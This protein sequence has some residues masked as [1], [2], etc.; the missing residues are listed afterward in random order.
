MQIPESLYL[1]YKQRPR[2]PTKNYSVYVTDP[3]D[4]TYINSLVEGIRNAAQ[5]DGFN[6]SQTVDF[7]VSFVQSLPYTFDNVTTPYDEYPRYPVETLVDN[8]GDCEDT[9]ILMAAVLQ[10]MGYGVV[11]ITPPKHCAVGVLGGEGISGTYWEYK[12]G[13]Y[14]FLETTGE[15]WKIGQL[16]PDYKG[17]QASVYG[18]VPV[19]VLT[20]HWTSVSEGGLVKLTVKVENLGSALADDVHVFAGFDAGATQVWNAERSPLFN[21]GP[22]GGWVTATLYLRPPANQRTRLVVEIVDDGYKVDE[23]RS[24][25]FQT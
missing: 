9:S 10:G 17:A 25:W 8:G 11:L 22:G 19:P 12:G 21:V 7:A 13:K 2:P 15:G 18:M 5:R 24:E 16:P 23:S 4:D 1:Y 3:G 20:H 14:Y 6:K